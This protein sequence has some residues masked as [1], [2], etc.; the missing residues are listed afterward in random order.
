[1]TNF[2]YLAALYFIPLS[3][4]NTIRYT[5]IVWAAILSVIFFKERFKIVNAIG[6]I[7]DRT[8]SSSSILIPTTRTTST[9]AIATTTTSSFYYYLGIGLTFLSALAK[10]AQLIA[11]KQLLIT[12]QPHSIMNFQYASVALLVSLFYSIIRRFWQPESYPSSAVHTHF[13]WYAKL[14]KSIRN[15]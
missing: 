3:D 4:L 9:A 15:L 7:F 14:L 2:T 12:K 8:S 1:G 5:Y 6:H 11:R 13:F 10:E